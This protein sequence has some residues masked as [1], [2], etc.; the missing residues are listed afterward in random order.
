MKIFN[1]VYS[2]LPD[3]DTNPLNLIY[4]YYYITLPHF[5][6]LNYYYITLPHLHVYDVL[7][8]YHQ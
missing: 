4:N 3:S 8:N 1:R 5:A 6:T 2:S 7:L